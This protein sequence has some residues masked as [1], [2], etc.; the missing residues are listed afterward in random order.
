MMPS[1]PTLHVPSFIPSKLLTCKWRTK[2]EDELSAA[3][4][5]QGVNSKELQEFVW[6]VE[7]RRKAGAR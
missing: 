4:L 5:K 7:K 3:H 6:Q 2:K 1:V